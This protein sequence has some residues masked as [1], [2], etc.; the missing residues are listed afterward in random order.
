MVV[1]HFLNV[2]AAFAG[3]NE[4]HLLRSAIGYA[5]Q[6]I[7]LLDVGTFFNIEASHF[8]AA[9]AGLVR[10]ELHAQNLASA[11][12]DVVD[13]PGH[14]HATALA[15]AACVN[16]RLDHPH[17]STQ[18]LGRFNGFLHSKGGN[19]AR[20]GHPELAQDFLALVFVDFHGNGSPDRNNQDF[21]A[22]WR[23]RQCA[24]KSYE[25]GI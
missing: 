13:R 22:H 18:L 9:G 10:H 8:L 5:R 15:A 20:H 17:R 3:S 19:A 23:P 14:L 7:L 11:S 25:T 6:V 1:R 4:G 24:V 16:L 2:H 12:P 21:T